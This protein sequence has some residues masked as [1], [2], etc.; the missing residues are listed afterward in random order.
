MA[1]TRE[2]KETI[3]ARVQSDPAFREA[4]LRE[5]VESMLQGDMATGKAIL[6][7]YINATDG[8]AD[9]EAATQKPVKSLMRMLGPKGNP[10]AENVFLIL[11]R[12]QDA[13]GIR[14]Q[15]RSAF[16][17]AKK[18]GARSKSR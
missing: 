5:A 15:V 7:D 6:R 13:L 18:R 16:K 10:Q 4:L 1:L 12:L 11:A 8:F 9:L 14:F 2:F 3:R 17:N